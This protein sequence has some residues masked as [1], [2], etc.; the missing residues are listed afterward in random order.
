MPEFKDTDEVL[1]KYLT[2][3]LLAANAGGESGPLSLKLWI[4]A[5]GNACLIE[6]S[7]K[8]IIGLDANKF[9]H[10]INK[11]PAWK[12]AVQQSYCGLP[13]NFRN[14]GKERERNIGKLQK[15]STVLLTI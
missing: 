12:T 3:A 11:M 14:S 7:K 6:L 13:C 10:E 9:Q 4:A 15:S 1:L 2:E 8:G 5:S